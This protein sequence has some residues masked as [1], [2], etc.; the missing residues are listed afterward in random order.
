MKRL[1]MHPNASAPGTKSMEPRD[2]TER[3]HADTERRI[4][5]AKETLSD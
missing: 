5:V 2:R 1:V 4:T 3:L